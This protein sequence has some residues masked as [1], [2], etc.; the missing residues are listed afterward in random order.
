MRLYGV[1]HTLYLHKYG[2]TE[3]YKTNQIHSCAAYERNAY[4]PRSRTFGCMETGN[5]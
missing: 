2:L 1:P 4:H 5:T 3:H